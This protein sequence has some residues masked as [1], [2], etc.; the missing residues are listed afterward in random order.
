MAGRPRPQSTLDHIRSNE[1]QLPSRPHSALGSTSTTAT[2]TSKT[3]L[4][5]ESAKR[6]R[7]TK[8][9]QPDSGE[10]EKDPL[11]LKPRLQTI[12]S[13]P[14]SALKTNTS[15]RVDSAAIGSKLPANAVKQQLLRPSS[16]LGRLQAPSSAS[17]K[18][19]LHPAE[20]LG[21]GFG[22]GTG[23]RELSAS[24]L[25]KQNLVARVKEIVA[26]SLTLA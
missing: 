6:L 5:P 4:R 1:G 7:I 26:I 18:Q 12:V 13:R 9:L 20:S 22:I 15:S 21:R 3:V 8:T 16:A 14:S 10:N 19:A 11:P 2:N 24:A 23:I 17:S 25:E